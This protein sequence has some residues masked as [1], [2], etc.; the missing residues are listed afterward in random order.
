MKVCLSWLK[1][2]VDTKDFSVKKIAD[3]LTMSGTKVEEIKKR[4]GEINNIVVG[5][6]ISI[7]KHENAEKLVIC[8]VLVEKN[9]TVD[10]V[11]GATNVLENSY[12]PVCLE[13]ATLFDGTKIKYQ[14][15]RGVLS[16]GMMCSLK[17]L[18]LSVENFPYAIEN[19][20]FLI[21][22]KCEIGQ[23][24]KSALFLQDYILDFEITSNRPDCLSVLGIAREIAATL[25]LPLKKNSYLNLNNLEKKA[26]GLN[27]KILSPNCKRYMACLVKNVEIKP[28][29]LWLRNRLVC[30]GVKPINNIVDITNYI[31]LELGVAMHAFDFKKL[32]GGQI[33][34]K[35]AKEN[36][37]IKTLDSKEYILKEQDLLICD[38]EK[39]IA[40]AGIIGAECSCVDSN[41]KEVVFE[42]ACFN[43][44]T[45]RKTSQRLKLKTEAAIRF[46][47]NLNPKICEETMKSALNLT[48]SLNA[49]EVL[50]DVLDVKNYEEKQNFVDFDKEKINKLLGLNL[51]EKE[52]ILIL[53]SLEFEVENNKVK[54][55]SFRV[56]IK[57]TADIAEEV[58]RIY[59]Y[60]KILSAP[61]KTVTKKTGLSL[62]QQ[63]ERTIKNTAV[64]L[65]LFECYSW[66][67]INPNIY[68]KAELK[69]EE[70]LKSSV[71]IK[72][73]F[74]EEKSFLKRHLAPF[75]LNTL[76]FNFK[77][78]NKTVALF[79]VGKIYL[80]KEDNSTEEKKKI[81]IGIYGDEF[82][83]FS[84]KGMVEKILNAAFVK[85]FE[86]KEKTTD[87]FH[88]YVCCE[89]LKNQEVLGVFGE[90][91]PTVLEN[92]KINKKVFIAELDLNLILKNS[93]NLITYKPISKFPA[94]KRDLS[95]ICDFN[96][97]AG[98][99][100]KTIKKNIGDILEKIEIFDVYC[101][102]QI[103]KNKKSIS[104]GLILRGKEKTLTDEFVDSKIKKT[105]KELE[106]IN[107]FLRN[108]FVN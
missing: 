89:V 50:K 69:K 30:S 29:P 53:N 37:K 10:I 93:S 47:K 101:G 11:T 82:N 51:T 44:E 100:E 106:K 96:L 99:I 58:A 36:Q 42:V 83:F 9:K 7:K 21:K 18:G 103:E 14:K 59:G 16:Q 32:S 39:P 61:A 54:V 20:I 8:K 71:E 35:D 13:N 23:D 31:M 86:F 85:D 24:I 78:N 43:G 46:E 87:F 107:V 4:S 6:V 94:L 34:V 80:K 88:P 77:N 62:K 27:V 45:V 104:F 17:E 49:G 108:S 67:I 40:I 74:G 64:Y 60:F 79:E 68:D 28:S 95:L 41:T 66:S 76:A 38:Q 1:D 55:P 12:V 72:N 15:L 84:L 75:M 102:E 92:F 22:E 65:G 56:D 26:S 52:M 90:V 70:I 33:I 97:A 105:L 2:F 98:E 48:V 3:A 19:G 91:K 63:L 73:P 81:A 25:S 5:K 57:N